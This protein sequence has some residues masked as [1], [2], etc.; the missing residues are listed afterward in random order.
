[1]SFGS[2]LARWSLMLGISM[3][4]AACVSVKQ[5]YR[6]HNTYVL[7]VRREGP[8]R[9]KPLTP[10]V[11]AVSPFRAA[12][13][14]DG[15]ELVRRFS[16]SRYET[17]HFDFFL[18]PP[19]EMVSDLTRQWLEDGGLFGQVAMPGSRLSPDFTLEGRL[20]NLYG[21]CR[22]GKKTKAFLEMQIF[23][24]DNQSGESRC[25]WSQKYRITS[26]SAS[27]GAED[28]V[29]AMNAALKQM[30]LEVETDMAKAMQTL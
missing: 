2:L 17:G 27:N 3:A 1:M 14:Y 29:E 19:A 30:L 16:E 10:K 24:L 22:K 25:V 13:P 8:G 9:E 21:D 23:L 5:P 15:Q 18:T 28:L 26:R 4:C 11:L 7:E 6:E 12:S 20:V